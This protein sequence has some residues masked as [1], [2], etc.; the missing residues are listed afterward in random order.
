MRVVLY[1]LLACAIAA[2]APDRP[3]FRRAGAGIDFRHQ[4]GGLKEMTRIVEATGPGLALFDADGDGDLDIY[5]V[6]GGWIEGI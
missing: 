3:E 4:F 6:N 1:S 5:F 2:A